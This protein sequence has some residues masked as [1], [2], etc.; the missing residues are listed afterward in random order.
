[1]RISLLRAA[2]SP[3]AEQAQGAHAFSWAVMPHVGHFLESDVPQVAYA[4]NSPLHLRWVPDKDKGTVSGL[5]HKA[6][7]SV[8]GAPSVILETVKRGDDD[9]GSE[10]TI[11]VRLYEAF[12]GHA[13]ARLNVSK[14]LHVSKAVV[15]NVLEEALYELEGETG[16]DVVAYPLKMRG[17]EVVT[18]KLVVGAKHSRTPSQEWVEVM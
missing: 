6:M 5:V 18:V 10:Q 3:D 15:A 7:F 14:K 1:M 11:V 2:T 9:H 13:R 12:G 16:D 17:F 8:T 4:F